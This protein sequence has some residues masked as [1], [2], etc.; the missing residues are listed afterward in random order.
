VL[1]QLL[2]TYQSKHTRKLFFAHPPSEY[3]EGR[4]VHVLVRQQQTGP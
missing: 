4:D 2:S 3:T 1:L